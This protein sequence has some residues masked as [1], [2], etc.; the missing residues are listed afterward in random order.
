LWQTRSLIASN[1]KVALYCIVRSQ[2]LSNYS[3]R[4]AWRFCYNCR[5]VWK[6]KERNGGHWLRGEVCG[7]RSVRWRA[8]GREVDQ[9]GMERGCAKGLPGTWF[10]Q[11]GCCGSWWMEGADGSWMTVG[12]VDWWVGVSSG[13]GSPG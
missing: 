1:S 6:G 13:T 3:N 8:P 4:T 11:G 2:E 12:M 5:Y 7:V 9:G 10:E